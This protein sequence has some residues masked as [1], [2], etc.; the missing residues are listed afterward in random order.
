M[1]HWGIAYVVGPNYNYAWDDFDPASLARSLSTARAAR[2]N[3]ERL[4][5]ADHRGRAGAD[6]APWRPGIP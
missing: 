3:A 1:A 6:R 4:A 2:E 5:A